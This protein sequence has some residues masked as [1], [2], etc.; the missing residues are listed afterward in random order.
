MAIYDGCSVPFEWI[1]K[2]FSR[3]N[4]EIC[5]CYHDYGFDKGSTI[6][7]RWLENL[8]FYWCLKAHG[9]TWFAGIAYA[10]VHTVGMPIFWKKKF[11]QFI[12][13]HH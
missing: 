4:S 6:L 11:D 2:I 12:M 13:K 10:A 5:C 3:K 7:D 8:N 1:R 9:H